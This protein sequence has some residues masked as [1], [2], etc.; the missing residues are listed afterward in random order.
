MAKLDELIAEL[1]RARQ[2]LQRLA[3]ECAAGKSKS[4]PILDAFEI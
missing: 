1:Q 2:S 4:C 3:T